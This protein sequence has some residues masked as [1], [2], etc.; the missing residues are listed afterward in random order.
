M[1]KSA[2]RQAIEINEFDAVGLARALKPLMMEASLQ[3][4]RKIKTHPFAVEH[5]KQKNIR[6]KQNG[7][8]PQFRT[9]KGSCFVPTFVAAQ[10][11]AGKM[12]IL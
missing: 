9:K 1:N 8:A 10:S 6:A 5:K 11:C 7:H 3:D 4:D 2:R 12:Y